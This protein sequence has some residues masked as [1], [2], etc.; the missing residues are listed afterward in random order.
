MKLRSKCFS[1]EQWSPGGKCARKIPSSQETRKKGHTHVW[2]TIASVGASLHSPQGPSALCLSLTALPQLPETGSWTSSVWRDE[3][4]R[5]LLTVSPFI[6]FLSED[7]DSHE[8]VFSSKG[9]IFLK[10]KLSTSLHKA[11]VH[12]GDVL[13]PLGTVRCQILLVKTS[14]LTDKPWKKG[15]RGCA[16]SQVWSKVLGWKE[17]VTLTCC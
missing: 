17:G 8:A 7:S 2:G 10:V 12:S 16:L 4:K 15:T 14:V 1:F 11:N 6:H 13:T 9:H 5:T 3:C